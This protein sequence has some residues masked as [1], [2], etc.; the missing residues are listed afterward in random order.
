MAITTGGV[1]GS[2]TPDNLIAKP[3][4]P[5]DAFIVEL[6]TSGAY[7]RGTVLCLESDGT[8]SVIGASGT[9]SAQTEKFDGDGEKISFTVAGKP[10]ALTSVKVG[11]T[12]RTDYTYDEATGQFA[13]DLGN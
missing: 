3:Y 11:G 6:E 10:A 5:T 1:I 13:A 8:Y 9:A 2:F 12:T 4:P 7:S